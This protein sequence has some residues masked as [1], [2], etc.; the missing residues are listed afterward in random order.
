VLDIPDETPAIWGEGSDIAWAQREALM[1]AGGNGVGKTTLAAQ[2]TRGR[3]GLDRA[4]LGLPVAPGRRR[5]LYLAMDRPAQTSRALR[6]CFTADERHVL[7]ECLL[8]WKG[9]PPLDLAKHPTVL[10]E[11]CEA[12]DADTVII[13]SLKDAAIG[14]SDDE[15]GAGWN[16]AR[17]GALVAGVEVVELHHN[18]K[19]ALE[20]IADVYG[21]AWL[22]AGCGSVI[23]LIG[24]PGDPI[25]GLRHLKQPVEE[26]GPF[27]ILHDHTHGVS[28]VWHGVDLLTLVKIGGELTARAAAVA[29]FETERPSPAQVEKA[30]RRLDALASRGELTRCDGR[31]PTEWILPDL[32]AEASR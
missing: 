23:G 11:M 17:Q 12:A 32:L 22:T 2:L 9:P 27:R 19:R 3:I 25:V 5:V 21:S 31:V 18:V 15:V 13:D 29:L 10:A 1:I 16:R 6:R 14:L 30:R 8:V 20:G 7:D 26:V 4:L 24:D 28:T